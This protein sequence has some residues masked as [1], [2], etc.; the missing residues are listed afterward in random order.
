MGN[1]NGWK[2]ERVVS[3]REILERIGREYAV[4]PL[5]VSSAHQVAKRYRYADG[6]AEFGLITSVTQPFC[7]GCTRARISADGK[8]YTCLFAQ[9]GLDLKRY[10]RSSQYSDA[11]LLD[12]LR[13]RWKARDDRY[14][15][16]R[17]AS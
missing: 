1:C 4:E 7:G 16:L 2:L 6:T 10:M 17:A 15:E 9:Q 8:L 14:S 3:G 5:D 13:G 12:L 11:G